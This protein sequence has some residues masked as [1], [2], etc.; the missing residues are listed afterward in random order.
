VVDDWVAELW[1][2]IIKGLKLHQ[3]AALRE[4]AE[5][6]W[7]VRPD[8]PKLLEVL[9]R[10]ITEI[11]SRSAQWPSRTKAYLAKLKQLNGATAGA[12]MQR[13]RDTVN[14]FRN[15]AGQYGFDTLSLLAQGYQESRL[16]QSVHSAVGAIGLMQVMPN[17]ETLLHVVDIHQPDPNVHAGTKFLAELMDV[18]FKGIPFDEQNRTLFAFAA[19][20]AGP[21]KVQSL[22]R[23]AEAQG[24][25]PNVWFDNVER[26]AAA[27]VGQETVRYVR[28]IYKYYVAYKLIE[29]AEAA[30]KAAVGDATPTAH[31]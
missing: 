3:K 4:G 8:D 12:D 15:Y 14:L 16:D 10:A 1:M 11:A 2:Q 26:V 20:N 31:P 7:V 6:A 13:F 23:E 30:K 17:T 22:R 9:N 28:N 29:E 19:Y 5:I 25:N 27:R 21:G 24:L 18:H